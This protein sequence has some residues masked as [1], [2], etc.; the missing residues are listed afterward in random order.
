MINEQQ[1]LEL[2]ENINSGDGITKQQAMDLLMAAHPDGCG[3]YVAMEWDSE[4]YGM[5]Q[6]N[7][8]FMSIEKFKALYPDKQ[9]ERV[10]FT[11]DKGYLVSYVVDFGIKNMVYHKGQFMTVEDFKRLCPDLKIERV[12]YRAKAGA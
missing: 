4:A 7:Y 5:I 10:K 12:I 6:Y 11:N 3:F 1:A 2:I 8:E 9:I